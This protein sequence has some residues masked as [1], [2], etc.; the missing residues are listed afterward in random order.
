MAEYVNEQGWQGWKAKVNVRVRE[1]ARC[2]LGWKGKDEWQ[3]KWVLGLPRLKGKVTD[4]IRERARWRQPA[5]VERE[6]M[7]DRLSEYKNCQGWKGKV[8]GRISVRA[9]LGPKLPRL[10][11]KD[12]WQAAQEKGQG[13][14]LA[15][16]HRVV[17]GGGGGEGEG[18]GS[19]WN[20][21]LECT[22]FLHT[23]LC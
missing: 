5:K 6:R 17:G 13:H 19:A 15:P 22:E 12:G 18:F 8:T 21:A 1:R 3:T 14:L 4:R 10:K 20:P 23:H 7:N 9:R 16:L 11:W 2:W